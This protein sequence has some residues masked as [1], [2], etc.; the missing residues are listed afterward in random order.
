MVRASPP[1]LVC[2]ISRQT[3]QNL[4]PILQA[5]RLSSALKRQEIETIHSASKIGPYPLSEF[6]SEEAGN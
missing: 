6:R 2:L 4:L 1:V 5:L 3:M